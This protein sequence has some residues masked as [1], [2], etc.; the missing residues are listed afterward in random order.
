M[1]IQNT[2]ADINSNQWVVLKFGGTSV[3]TLNNWQKIKRIVKDHIK[4]R[5]KVFIVHSALAT[6]SN[7]LQD[8]S[9]QAISNEHHAGLDEFKQKHQTLLK[10]MQL[11][12]SLLEEV[13]QDLQRV[14]QGVSLLKELTDRTRAEIMACGELAATTIGA[15]YLRKELKHSVRYL[16]ARD[17][18]FSSKSSQRKKDYLNVDCESDYDEELYQAIN[19]D[20]VVITQG[21]IAANQKEETVLIGRGGSDVSAAYFAAKIN[22]SECQIWTDVPGMFTAN[23]NV[24]PSARLIQRLSYV[25]AQEIAALGAKVL[26]PRSLHPVRQANIPLRIK[27]TVQP[28]QPGTLIEKHPSD[29]QGVCAITTRDPITLISMET[30]DMWGQSGFLGKA[31]SV[32]G[33]LGISIDL[34][35]TSET[36]VTVSLDHGQNS[37]DEEL[38]NELSE[39]LATICKVKLLSSCAAVSIIGQKVSGILSQIAPSLE[40]F[41][42][43]TV[44]LLSQAA[45]DLNITLVVERDQANKIANSLHEYLIGNR[46]NN[47]QFGA[48]ALEIQE[49]IDAKKSSSKLAKSW[50]EARVN[51][52]LDVCPEDQAV[53]VYDRN[54]LSKKAHDLLSIQA[55]DQV[56][57]ACKANHNPEVLK[58]FHQQGLGFECVS[59]SELEYV[60]GLFPDIDPTRILFTP[61]FAARH[62][63]ALGLEKNVYL[64]VDSVYPL[65]H[66]PELFSGKDILL[67]IDPKTGKGHHAYVKTAGKRSK[68]GIPIEEL[69]ALSEHCARHHIRVIGLHAHA[70]SGILQTGHWREHAELLNECRRWF[71]DVRILDLGGGFGIQDKFHQVPL[72]IADVQ[73]SLQAFKQDF[74]DLHIWLEPGRYLVAEAG[75]LLA[76]VTQVKTKADQH[77]I[78]LN[79]GM[80]SL[81][82]PALYGAYHR[83]VNLSKLDA[84]IEQSASIVGPICES[85]DVLGRNIPMP[86]TSEGDVILVANA[87]AYGQVMSS[88]YN[89]RE[90]AGE[91][92]I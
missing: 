90:P 10:N 91:I 36:V 64:T 70:G 7:L 86:A 84:E 72:D 13:Y 65:Q 2:Q 18:L 3:E 74:P 87:G 77:F 23:P 38:L 34:V 8:I 48:T 19:S 45:N 6:M 54:T 40:A 68:F 44:Y 67:R 80:N 46:S 88:R 27:S 69:P 24:T 29:L 41:E 22:A 1:S 47:G 55:A 25:E 66:W 20:D 21:F 5:S 76:R 56:F 60:T 17:W 15:A 50:W 71:N 82:R 26:H 75:A 79:T 16:D 39:K 52:L 85:A 30:L 92:V 59:A 63:Y 78:G 89:M 42:T 49:L 4:H 83:I 62:E 61:N 35:S 57:F 73:K 37:I 12:E 32:F 14:L 31:F 9:Q 33:Q 58:L 51:E 11:S 81:I 53:Y 28:D 43:N